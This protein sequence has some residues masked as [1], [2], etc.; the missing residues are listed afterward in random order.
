MRSMPRITS[1]IPLAV[2]LAAA[3]H[4][5]GNVDV[6]IN[7]KGDLSI[8]G[9]KEANAFV[10]LAIDADT[11]TVT[12][13]GGT[14]INDGDPDVAVDIQYG[15]LRDLKIKMGSGDDDI[16]FNS[17]GTLLNFRKLLYKGGSGNDAVTLD[18][19]TFSGKGVFDFQSGDVGADTYGAGVDQ[20]AIFLRTTNIAG[21]LTI[22][23]SK[24]ND[25][26]EFNGVTD[27]ENEYGGKLKINLGAGDDR[28]EL[29][30]SIYMGPVK[31]QMKSGDDLVVFTESFFED[32]V[33]IDGGKDEDEYQDVTNV[34]AEPVVTKKVEILPVN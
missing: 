2:F 30:D 22:K 8:K 20:E 10:A 13:S 26:F 4:A 24:T 3:A 19:S 32:S 7:N 29:D 21:N 6:S 15:E 12:P 17:G 23:G 18:D 14:S 27:E 9:D 16:S 28:V 31:I 11:I 33:T 34:F 25:D 1:I 5:A